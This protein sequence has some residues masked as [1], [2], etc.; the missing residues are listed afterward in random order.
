MY[1]VHS[2]PELSVNLNAPRVLL[3]D[4][5]TFHHAETVSLISILRKLRVIFWFSS[6]LII[7]DSISPIFC[8]KSL[9]SRPE[10]YQSRT[11]NWGEVNISPEHLWSEGMRNLATFG[12]KT[13]N[14]HTIPY[15]NSYEIYNPLV[16]R[17]SYHWNMLIICRNLDI[18]SANWKKCDVAKDIVWN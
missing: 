12:R 5:G 6:K 15:G 17:W 1:S 16:S 13:R 7:E 8:L 14:M 11:Y 10:Q 9:S 2:F 4:L 3:M 18:Y